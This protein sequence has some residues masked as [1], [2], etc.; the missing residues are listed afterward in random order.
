M[1]AYDGLPY[2]FDF[3]ILLKIVQKKLFG[4]RS[5]SKEGVTTILLLYIRPVVPVRPIA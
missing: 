5:Y 4:N 2:F 3:E 1:C